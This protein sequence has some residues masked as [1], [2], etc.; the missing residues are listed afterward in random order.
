[1]PISDELAAVYAT[2]PRDDYYIETL[3]LAHSAFP[4]GARFI[5]N[6]LAG[7]SALI[8]TG[9]LVN[10]EYLPFAAIPP[11]SAEDNNISLN[12]SIDNASVTLMEQLEA[13]AAAP[14]EAIIIRYRVYLSSNNTT[15]QNDPPLKLDI[16]SVTANQDV[17]TFTAGLSNLR[18]IPFPN[19]V[20]STALYPGLKR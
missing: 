16:L 12:V 15:V 11:N 13:L 10:F 1:M 2:A 4:N 8:E 5:T 18:A 6:Q 14:T 20:Y 7:W 17:I 3:E 9:A 19:I